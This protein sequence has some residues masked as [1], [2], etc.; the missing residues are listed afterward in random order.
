MRILRADTVHVASLSPLLLLC[1][2]CLHTVQALLNPDGVMPMPYPID[3]IYNLVPFRMNVTFFADAMMTTFNHTENT[4]EMTLTS[5]FPSDTTTVPN[6]EEVT[7]VVFL[8]FCQAMDDLLGP[9]FYGLEK[10]QQ[11]DWSSD[12]TF[13]YANNWLFYDSGLI[14][15]TFEY[16][17]EAVYDHDQE[18]G[19][20]IQMDLLQNTT[21]LL[22][23]LESSFSAPVDS[24]EIDTCA[25]T[26]LS[27]QLL[28]TTTTMPIG[29]DTQLNA[30]QATL[31]TSLSTELQAIFDNRTTA[32]VFRSWVSLP[33]RGEDLT[34]WIQS[35]S[36]DRVC[37]STVPP[38][39]QD[40][41]GRLA[42]KIRQWARTADIQAALDANPDT[43]GVTLSEFAYVAGSS[44]V[45]STGAIV[46]I[47]IACVGVV[48]VVALLLIAAYT[49]YHRKQRGA[50]Q[51]ATIGIEADTMQQPNSSRRAAPKPDIAV[52]EEGSVQEPLAAVDTEVGSQSPQTFHS[53]IP[54]QRQ[55]AVSM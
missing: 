54:P 18:E 30:I 33:T 9:S 45:L 11:F 50:G 48:L 28:M 3:A 15:A 25:L 34:E 42:R 41:N 8:S 31:E 40:Y 51:A 46:G 5:L 29:E 55:N 1:G 22:S 39:V 38:P 19:R 12:W 26:G 10:F 32:A 17:P 16:G 27:Y 35:Y 2:L 44:E 13:A 20:N 14:F 37:F 4:T 52:A 21:A 23:F 36:I 43:Q 53:R 6:N 7:D 47:V 49:Y 24:L